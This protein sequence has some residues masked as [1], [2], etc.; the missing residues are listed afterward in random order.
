RVT[1]RPV[2][3][4]GRVGSGVVGSGIGAGVPRKKRMK[5]YDISVSIFLY[6]SRIMRATARPL[7]FF[8]HFVIALGGQQVP[9]ATVGGCPCHLLQIFPLS[10]GFG[11]FLRDLR[12]HGVQSDLLQLVTSF[13]F[14]LVVAAVQQDALL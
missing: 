14:F 3:P 11:E 2:L 12:V 10:G 8:S 5:R 6:Q 7:L 1:W 4:S 13:S 9:R